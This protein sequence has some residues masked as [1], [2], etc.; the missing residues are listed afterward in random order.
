MYLKFA[1]KLYLKCSHPQKKGN[2]GGDVSAIY[3]DFGNLV[4]IYIYQNIAFHIFNAYNFT[5]QK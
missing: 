1:K 3:F 4:T 2:Y 5:C